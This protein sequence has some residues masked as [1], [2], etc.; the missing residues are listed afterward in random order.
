MNGK[1][2]MLL[3]PAWSTMN[4]YQ[5]IHFLRIILLEQY[6]ALDANCLHEPCARHT[7]MHQIL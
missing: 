3:A 7:H 5:P 1:E 6:T 4:C 2:I